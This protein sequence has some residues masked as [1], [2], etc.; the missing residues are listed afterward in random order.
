MFMVVFLSSKS[1]RILTSILNMYGISLPED[2]QK[3][4]EKFIVL[5]GE[6]ASSALQRHPMQP[7]IAGKFQPPQPVSVTLSEG[8]TVKILAKFVQKLKD[9]LA[10]IEENMDMLIFFTLHDSKLFSAYLK[11]ELQARNVKD[12]NS[13]KQALMQVNSLLL[14][15]SHGEVTYIEMTSN[16]A[17]ALETLDIEKEFDILL[18]SEQLRKLPGIKTTQGLRNVRCMVDL[19]KVS[20]RIRVVRC[21]CE[22]YQLE[23]C[24]ED[25]DLQNLVLLSD[26]FMSS[27]GRASLTLQIAAEKMDTVRSL[28]DTNERATTDGYEYLDIFSKIA[29]SAEFY[30]FICEK[31]FTGENGQARFHQQYQLITAQL[32]HEEYDEAVLNLLYTAYKLILPFTVKDQSFH[33]LLESVKQ[34]LTAASPVGAAETTPDY[35]MQIETVN[36]NINL[37]QLWFSRAEV[38]I[39]N[40]LMLVSSHVDFHSQIC[41]LSTIGL[42][43]NF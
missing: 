5:P 33:S 4:M 14:Q 41:I 8:F 25:E 38:C 9:F 16:D 22:Q 18:K 7:S 43:M 28:I 11:Y 40:G 21:V 3:N 12:M 20:S 26:E 19:L 34:M 13:F 39:P 10:P 24:L 32:Q 6:K 36:R 30:Q 2:L 17:I 15:L 37:I 29:D 23:K 1:R 42:N 35:I 31:G 27:E